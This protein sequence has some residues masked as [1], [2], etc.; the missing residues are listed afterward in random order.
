MAAEN[1]LKQLFSKT[2]RSMQKPK[3]EGGGADARPVLE[4]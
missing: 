4:G 3:G 1:W 2:Y